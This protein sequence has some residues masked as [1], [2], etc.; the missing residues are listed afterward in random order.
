MSDV[1]VIG[2][3]AMGSALARALVKNGHRVTVWNRTTAKAEPL[4]R[5]GAKRA[6]SAAAAVA[7]SPFVVVCVDTYAIA[8]TI[9]DAKEVVPSLRGR[10][11]V[12]LGTGAP[13]E[14]RE[15]E[16]WARD[17]G[18]AYLDGALLAY[19]DQIGTPDAV[20]LL[21]GAES[22]FRRCEPWLRSFVP[23][24]SYLG[25]KVGA[26]SATDC[27]VLSF[28][29]GSLIGA[30]HGA[31]ICESE[32]LDVVEFGTMLNGLAP[33]TAAETKRL[34][35]QIRS[36]SYQETIASLGTYAGCADR[37][38]SHARDAKIDAAFPAFASGLLRKAIDAGFGKEDLSALV[39]VL[40][41]K[42]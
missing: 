31:A 6:E 38:A 34:A 26:S 2:L 24:P 9:L 29:L 12:Q 18:A 1:S 39:K 4:V 3:G 37:I 15:S 27:A 23:T 21:S 41:A 20:V 25:E 33:V 7:A 16:A 19:P 10:V 36:G 35:E 11:L 17:R 8:R 5:A 14:A 42:A 22:A 32:G 40:R 30:I 13:Q 28:V